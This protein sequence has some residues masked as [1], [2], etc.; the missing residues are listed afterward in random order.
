VSDVLVA[1]ESFSTELSNGQPVVVQEGV[2]RVAADSELPKRFPHLFKEIEANLHFG[3]EE[4]TAEPG[5]SRGRTDR[6]PVEA[7]G[8]QTQAKGA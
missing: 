5:R 3:V 7:S 1:K 4:M 6:T 8:S 2:T